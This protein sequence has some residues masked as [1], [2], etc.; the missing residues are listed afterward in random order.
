MQQELE[1]R[2]M[3]D[4]PWFEARNVWTGE[5]LGVAHGCECDDGWLDLIYDLCQEIDDEYKKLGKDISNLI[6][7]QIKEK[8]GG[9][10]FYINGTYPSV[11]NIIHN[12]ENMSYEVC[13]ICGKPGKLM[14]SGSWF[15]TL[16]EKCA[17]ELG[18]IDYNDGWYMP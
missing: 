11:N 18:Y 5:L 4:F 12:Y 1:E 2:I 7:Y 9:L 16:C 13:E 3:Q 15:K 6:I 8:Y 17:N 14:S 10:R